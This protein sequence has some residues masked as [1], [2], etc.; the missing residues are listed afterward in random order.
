VP[1]LWRDLR[2][3]R[4]RGTIPPNGASSSPPLK[5]RTT[6]RSD[7]LKALSSDEVRR[8]VGKFEK[9]NPY[10]PKIV[11]GSILNIVEEMNFDKAGCQR[12][13]YG[14][15]ISAKRYA[16]YEHDCES[17]HLIKVSEH[18]QGLYYRPKEGR[19]SDCEVALW[20]KEG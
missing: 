6:D 18:G 1:D 4:F 5:H 7:A 13:L 16:L 14:Y 3:L 20:I 17:I 12:Q 2:L 9:L 10:N 8:I 11:P 19:D 15:G